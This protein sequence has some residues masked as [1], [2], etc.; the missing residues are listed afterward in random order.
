MTWAASR[1]KMEE[2]ETLR[3]KSVWLRMAHPVSLRQ[4]A[5]H[6]ADGSFKGDCMGTQAGAVVH[7]YFGWLKRFLKNFIIV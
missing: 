4:I 6:E 2:Q 3:N 7:G 1:K 5:D